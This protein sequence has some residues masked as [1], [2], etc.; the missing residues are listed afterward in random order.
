MLEISALRN[1]TGYS[2]FG[3]PP[4]VCIDL[5]CPQSPELDFDEKA[6]MEQLLRLEL[7]PELESVEVRDPDCPAAARWFAGLTLALLTRAGHEPEGSIV[8]SGIE[9]GLSRVII[10]N[11]ECESCRIAAELSVKL[12]NACANNQLDKT[13]HVELETALAN[14]SVRAIDPNALLLKQAARRRELP[15]MWLDQFPFEEAPEDRPIRFGLQKIGQGSAGRL[16]AGPMPQIS[17]E[18]V[19][20]KITDRSSLMNQLAQAGL[21]VPPHESGLP[22][23]GTVSRAIRRADQ[24]GYPVMIKG[25]RKQTF[26][27]RHR[28]LAVFGPI[29]RPQQIERVFD[30]VA[31][32]GAGVW[33]ERHVSGQHYRFLVIGGRVRAV[34]RCSP[35]LITGDGHLSVAELITASGRKAKT[36][37]RRAAWKALSRGDP[38]LAA[39]LDLA[40]VG[41]DT[42]LPK[43][44]RVALRG[45]GNPYNGGH[46]EDVTD[47]IPREIKEL[48]E[49]AAACCDLDAIAGVDMIFDESS[50]RQSDGGAVIVDVLPDPDLLTHARPHQGVARDVAADLIET[51]FPPGHSGRIPLIAVTGTNGKTTTVRMIDHM[52]RHGFDCPG[53]TTTEGAF[54]AN[55]LIREGDVAGIIGTALLLAEDSLDAAVLETARGGLVKR[56]CPFEYCDVGVCLNVDTDHLGLDGIHT[57]D[58]MANIKA[59]IIRRA[60]NCAVLNADDSRVLAMQAETCAAEIILVSRFHDSDAIVRH[61]Q[62]GGTAVVTETCQGRDWIVA[63]EG[64]MRIEIMPADEIPATLEAT[65]GFNVDNAL[66]AIAAARAVNLDDA[67]IRDAMSSFNADHKHNPGRFNIYDD[68]PCTVVVDHAQNVSAMNR[69]CSAVQA[70]HRP[71]RKMLLLRGLGNRSDKELHELAR[72]SSGQFDVYVCSNFFELRGRRPDEVPDLLECA[73]REHGVSAESILKIPDTDQAV[74]H[75]LDMADAGDL[76][77]MLFVGDSHAFIRNKLNEWSDRKVS[78]NNKIV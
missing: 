23:A 59:E 8:E 58:E 72:A 3:D 46:C 32:A 10:R 2:S 61:R 36:V 54:V 48:A 53:R 57:L 27:H 38:D 35:P 50:C 9:P 28:A 21:P 18:Q 76:V 65:V 11:E 74:D 24:L 34:S 17:N 49:T 20:A 41:H 64:D 25:A 42:V 16:L 7:E 29:D 33:V 19:L 62:G 12:L 75:M 44:H 31:V 78:V 5:S 13:L 15:V 4:V 70:L 39:R 30:S 68:L 51:L 63:Y 60:S 56:G 6:A 1:I 43:G 45:E 47:D 66:F 22:P 26:P 14:I 40:A 69:L 73:L 37:Q 71:G 77:V 67:L 52:L 55:K